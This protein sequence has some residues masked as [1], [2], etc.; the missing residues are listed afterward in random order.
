V[1]WAPV[2]AW[3]ESRTEYPMATAV[4][5]FVFTAAA[6]AESV[7]AVPGAERPRSSSSGACSLPAESASPP[8]DWAP[9]LAFP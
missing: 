7:V 4:A 5:A 9:C 3:L 8:G 1:I 6:F 2:S